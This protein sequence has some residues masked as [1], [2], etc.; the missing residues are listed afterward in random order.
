MTY[1]RRY[2]IAQDILDKKR[3]P[4][5]HLAEKYDCSYRT[6]KRDVAWI[7]KQADLPSIQSIVADKVVGALENIDCK[8]DKKFIIAMGLPFLARGLPQKTEISG[9]L[10]DIK[11]FWVKNE[12]NSSDKLQS[13]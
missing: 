12:S 4:L 11:I 2:N 8:K 6:I 13:T 1:V 7:R 5:K 3:V 10:K 9:E